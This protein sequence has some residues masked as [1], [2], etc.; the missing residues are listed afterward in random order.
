MIN[1]LKW[2]VA[3]KELAELERW[4]V[5]TT[6]ARQWLAESE[7][8]SLALDHIA[9]VAIGISSYGH[10]CET[11]DELHKIVAAELKLDAL[12]LGFTPAEIQS[13]LDRVRWAEGLIR[14]LPAD[15]DGRN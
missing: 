12:A 5:G 10:I 2:L 11:R 13:G 3:S 4:R 8:V 6:Q 7:V 14:Q 15:H 9:D 1:S